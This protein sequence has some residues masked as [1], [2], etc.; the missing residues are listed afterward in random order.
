MIGERHVFCLFFGFCFGLLGVANL[1]G[2]VGKGT[3]ETAG[4]LP[5]LH[6]GEFWSRSS[7]EKSTYRNNGSGKWFFKNL[8]PAS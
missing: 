5:S 3:L 2:V 4:V 7:S 8:I 6:M 1:K